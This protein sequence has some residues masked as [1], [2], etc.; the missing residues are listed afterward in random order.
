[1][2]VVLASRRRRCTSAR[3]N[4][5]ARD[6]TAFGILHCIPPGVDTTVE[7]MAANRV[8]VVLG[9]ID[10]WNS[11]TIGGTSFDILACLLAEKRFGNMTYM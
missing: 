11:L 9:V 2:Q 6:R 8:I 5:K 3:D 1:M 4:T 10:R 7:S